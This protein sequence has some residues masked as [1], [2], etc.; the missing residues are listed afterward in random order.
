MVIN[1]SLEH[2]KENEMGYWQHFKFAAGHGIRCIRAGVL[3]IIHSIIPAFFPYAGTKLINRL[4]KYFI[5][6]NEWKQWIKKQKKK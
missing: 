3:L 5:D 2:L 1:K 4:N 6:H